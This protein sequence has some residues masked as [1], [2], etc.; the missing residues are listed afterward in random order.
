MRIAGTDTGNVFYRLVHAIG[1]CT[2]ISIYTHT[3]VW[4]N[5]TNS[6]KLVFGILKY[7]FA[8]VHKIGRVR[9]SLVGAARL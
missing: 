2:K 4:Q 3:L 9:R 6:E 7:I 1:S 8:E 5:T